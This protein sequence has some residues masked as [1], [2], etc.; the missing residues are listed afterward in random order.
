MKKGRMIIRDITIISFDVGFTLIY[1][2]PPI[3]EVYTYIAKGFGY[4][5]DKKKV[6][7]RFIETWQRMN[8]QTR[9]RSKDNVQASEQRSLVW[10]REIFQQSTGDIISPEDMEPLFN[11]CY[12]AYASGS[13]WKI[14]QDVLETLRNLQSR[15]YR[16]VVLSN[17]DHRLLT[18]LHDLQLD[19]FFEKIYISTLIGHAKPDPGAFLHILKDLGIPASSLLHVGD[20][21]EEDIV[22][23]MKAGVRS[24]LVKRHSDSSPPDHSIP[25]VL[26]LRDLL[27]LLS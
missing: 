16:L 7:Q 1:P 6:Q 12:N 15:G 27:S 4:S 2:D 14:Y 5:L 22:G 19:T 13:Y 11:A 9:G 20:T 18:T 3:G 17:W 8:I 26:S 21:V 24:V 23:A 10:W 25:A